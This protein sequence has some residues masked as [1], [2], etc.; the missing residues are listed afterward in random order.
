MYTNL[1][2]FLCYIFGVGGLF[3]DYFSIVAMLFFIITGQFGIMWKNRAGAIFMIE[4]FFMVLFTPKIKFFLWI[5]AV[6]LG[7][8]AASRAFGVFY[9]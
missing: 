6:L 1:H 9:G 8:S 2:V 5:F 3:F 4:S 7:L